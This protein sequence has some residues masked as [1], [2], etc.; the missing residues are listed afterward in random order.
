[1]ETPQSLFKMIHLHAKLSTLFNI[2]WFKLV[3]AG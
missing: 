1:M 3:G 2:N